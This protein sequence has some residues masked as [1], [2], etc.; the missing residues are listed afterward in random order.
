MWLFVPSVY[1]PVSEDSTLDSNWQPEARLFVTSSGTPTPRLSSWRGWKTKPWHRLLF[2][3]TL[4]PLMAQRGVERLILSLVDSRAKTCQSPVNARDSK[5]VSDLLSGPR[6]SESPMS[7]EP[8]TSSL[9]TSQPFALLMGGTWRTEQMTLFGNGLLA[10]F[11]ETW[12]KAGGM[13]NGCVYERPTLAHRIGESGGL[14]WPTATSRD[15]KDGACQNAN[16]E[17]NALLGRVAVNFHP[18]PT[19]TGLESLNT[20]TRRSWPTPNAFDS[21]DGTAETMTRWTERNALKKKLNPK[22]GELHLSLSTAAIQDDKKRRLNPAFVEWLMGLP[23]GWTS[24][25]R[26]VSDAWGMPL[27]LFKRQRHSQN[28]SNE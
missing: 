12:P 19:E 9:R 2:G 3:T 6:C 26:I 7:A 16:V 4:Q 1:S 14:C 24:T 11:S 10:P 17:E 18:A 5:K 8:H 15:W 25:D 27:Y 23:I 20:S 28:C 21:N 22:L 13:R